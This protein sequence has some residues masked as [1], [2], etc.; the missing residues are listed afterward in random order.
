MTAAIAISFFSNI[1]VHETVSSH[2]AS[3]GLLR[4]QNVSEGDAVLNVLGEEG[5]DNAISLL[6]P[7]WSAVSLG[8]HM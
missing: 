8:E 3:L 7:V 2:S 1:L 5:G 6:P 4:E